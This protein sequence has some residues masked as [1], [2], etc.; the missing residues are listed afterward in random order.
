MN[1][2]TFLGLLWL[3]L[4]PFIVLTHSPATVITIQQTYSDIDASQTIAYVSG[5]ANL[6]TMPQQQS[7]HMQDVRQIVVVSTGIFILVSAALLLSDTLITKQFLWLTGT[8]IILAS[9]LYF[10]VDFTL[11][12]EGFH[13]LLFAP[14]SYTFAHSS[15]LISR[16]PQEFFRHLLQVVLQIWGVSTGVLT[17]SYLLRNE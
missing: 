4:L 1:I 3:F 15:F 10:L 17:L 14:G 12:F 5:D 6:P 13:R 16:F 11:L 9:L 7:Q 8:S 2:T